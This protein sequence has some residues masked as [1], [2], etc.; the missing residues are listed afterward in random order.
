MNEIFQL[1]SAVVYRTGGVRFGLEGTLVTGGIRSYTGG[2]RHVRQRLQRFA[3][4][5]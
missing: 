3:L 2:V 5:G 4:D 1:P